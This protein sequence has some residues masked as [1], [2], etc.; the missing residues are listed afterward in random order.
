MLNI[1]CAHLVNSDLMYMP[2]HGYRLCSYCYSLLVATFGNSGYLALGGLL[3][4]RTHDVHV[5]ELQHEVMNNLIGQ[6]LQLD[7]GLEIESTPAFFS[8]DHQCCSH[9]DTKLVAHAG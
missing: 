8:V 6:T 4:V 5:A 2:G 9:S 3:F 7:A 1:K